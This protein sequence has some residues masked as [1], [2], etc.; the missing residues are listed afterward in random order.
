MNILKIKNTIEVSVRKGFCIY[1]L[2]D[3]NGEIVY[4]GKSNIS[5][6]GRI[7]SHQRDKE[8]NKAFIKEMVS[9]EEMELEEAKMIFELQP[10]YNKKLE[11]K[12]LLGVLSKSDIRDE[13]QASLP[14][15]KK[16]AKKYNIE[17]II[18]FKTAYWPKK[19]I[20]A[21]V[22]YLADNAEK[23]KGKSINQI[24]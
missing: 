7:G 3:K 13:T 16:A 11:R 9:K 10:K 14:T 4:V 22:R 15:I 1:F 2:T 5:T 18:I 19:I 21:V 8:F 6:L 20:G 12:D 23:N 24:R 17:P